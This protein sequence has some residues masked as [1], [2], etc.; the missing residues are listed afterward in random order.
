MKSEK[1]KM[2]N[3]RQKTQN[4]ARSALHFSHFH[5]SFFIRCTATPVIHFDNISKRYPGGHDALSQINLRL[6]K[7]RWRFLPAIP[8]QAKA[9]C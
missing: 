1:R 5:F 8:A 7:G 2:K 3:E 6:A 4:I 9:P